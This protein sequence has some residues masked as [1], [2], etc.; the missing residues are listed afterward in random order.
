M[1]VLRGVVA[2]GL[3]ASLAGPFSATPAAAQ[4]GHWFYDRYNDLDRDARDARG[5]PPLVV[6]VPG[7]GPVRMFDARDERRRRMQERAR[8]AEAAERRR[9]AARAATTARTIPEPRRKPKIIAAPLPRAKPHV[10]V[11]V[12]DLPVPPAPAATLTTSPPPAT[13]GDRVVA[14]REAPRAVPAEPVEP[15]AASG[16]T[17]DKARDIVAGFGFSEVS[18]TSCAGAAY[19]FNARR[20]GKPFAIELSA[21]SGDLISV[22]KL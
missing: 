4:D 14:V 22:R 2:A 11:A 6:I 3:A 9:Q 1:S 18:A 17:C 16:L 12:P 8:A 10:V 7:Y 13:A 21:E 15:A 20:D 5:R 19:G